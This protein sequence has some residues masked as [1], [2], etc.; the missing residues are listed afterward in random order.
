MIAI[1]GSSAAGTLTAGTN[2]MFSAVASNL[3]AGSTYR[4]RIVATDPQGNTMMSPD[5]TFT[6][7]AT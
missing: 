7:P 5:M 4:Y 1:Y 6:T 3:T 2:T